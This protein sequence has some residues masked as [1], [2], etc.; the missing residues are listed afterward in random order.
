MVNTDT[1]QYR[2]FLQK[3]QRDEFR[4]SALN[5]IKNLL[6]FKPPSEASVVIRDAG[7]TE[8]VQ[9]LNV[10]DRIQVDLTC[11]VLKLC[12]EKFEV[13]DIIRQYTGHVMYLL[14]HEKSCVRRLA[15][16]EVYKATSTNQSLLPV[17]QYIDV[18]VAVAQLVSDKDVGVANKAIMIT[19]NLPND[20]YP[21]ILDEM[22]IALEYD[23]S[24]KCNAFEVIVNISSRSPELLQLSA[25]HGYLDKLVSELD[26]D[27]VLYHLNILELMTRLATTQ[28]GINHIVKH[29]ALKKVGELVTDLPNNPLCGLTTPGYM[30][31]FGVI[32]HKYPQEIFTKYP[33][34]LN[35]MFDTIDSQ[36]QATLPIALDTLA[37]VGSTIEGKL[38]L[39]ALGSQYTQAVGKVA[40]MITTGTSD[41]KVRALHCFASLVGV[42]TGTDAPKT[43]PIDHRVT[44]MTRE[45]F[46]TLSVQPGPMEVLVE[47]CKNPFPDIR[48]A[49]F[50]LLDAVCQ[51]QW[52]EELVARTA[53]F[54]EF[55]LDRS[56]SFT[57]EL[58]ESKYDIVK[59]LSHSLAFDNNTVL[60][61]QLY[62]EQGPF[63]SETEMQ[64]A[65]EEGD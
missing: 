6:A 21:K 29:G 49:G 24:S 63:Y 4:P 45:W 16:D 65:T 36:D 44:L 53:G 39:A 7:I 35:L 26:T 43:R 28:Q 64:V 51:H 2:A 56:V 59:R 23:S 62:V 19:S 34:L 57:K 20:A 22:R 25:E 12:F 40:Q 58:K 1:E 60:R 27:D 42:D 8:I 3:L 50:S 38:S 55:L 48:S 18:F 31:F 41:I 37:F 11:E 46:R 17:P 30:K 10:A 32:A 15:V 9:C 33:V 54:V 47:I 52:G 14:R 13:G 5:D 61:L